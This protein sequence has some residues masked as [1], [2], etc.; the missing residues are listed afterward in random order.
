MVAPASPTPPSGKKD[1]REQAR[2]TAR[3]EREEAKKRQRRNRRLLQGGLGVLVIAI[4]VIVV[5]VVVNV[6]GSGTSKGGTAAPRNLASDG[7]LLSGSGGDSGTITATRTAAIKPNGKPIATDAS[8]HTNT[9]NI[10]TYIDYLC[11]YCQQ[12][13]ATNQAQIESWVKAGT[14]TLEIH[15]ISILDNSSLGSKYSTRAAN[16]AA[17][18]ATYDPDNFFAVN[19]ALFANQPTENTTGLS[20]S[21]LISVLKGAGSGSST[22]SSCITS[23][24]FVDWVASASTRATTGPLANTSVAKVT[25]TP[26]VLVNGTQ[27]SGSLTDA[28]AFASF[29][30]AQASN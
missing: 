22:I 17:C 23:Q 16:A 1:R 14:A 29:V 15:P 21:K 24:K 27:Y 8:K 6:S 13:E 19:A 26:T 3:L 4:V 7:V 10:V 2:E 30:A 25:G 9:V 28:D 5:V 18:V 11:P 12:F 20:D